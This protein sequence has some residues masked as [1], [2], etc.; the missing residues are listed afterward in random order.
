MID[1]IFDCKNDIKKYIQ[2]IL[3]QYHLHHHLHIINT[4]LSSK[5]DL[6]NILPLL[7]FNKERLFVD[8]LKNEEIINH[9]DNINKYYQR[10]GYLQIINTPY[11]YIITE[12]IL[13]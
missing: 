6:L 1:R 4:G 9:I 10:Y 7:G 5:E 2:D 12:D 3:V 13:F 11:K 8:D